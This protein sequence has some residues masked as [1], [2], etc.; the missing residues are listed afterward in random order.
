MAEV[1]TNEFIP[2]YASPPGETL[3]EILEVRGMSQAELAARMGMTPKTINEI[4]KGKAPITPETAIKLEQVLDVQAT[5]WN[6]R[7]Q[8][9]REILARVED[10][11][12]LGS[13]VSWLREIPVRELINRGAIPDLKDKTE[14]VQHALKFFGVASE[15]QWHEVWEIVPVSYRKSP[16]VESSF[17]SLAAWLRLGELKAQTIEC[18][19][20]DEKKF[21]ESLA[22][23]RSL[24]MQPP[25]V[26][27]PELKRLCAKSGV[28]L[29][30]VSE[31]QKTRVSGAIRWV[32]PY[33]AI[34][35]L[36]LRYK[37]DDQFWFTFFHEAGHVILHSSKEIFLE[38][39]DHKNTKE[40]EADDFAANFLVPPAEHKRLMIEGYSSK[41]AIGGFAKSIGVAPGIVVGRLQHDGLLPMSYC[42]DLKRRF[43]L[44]D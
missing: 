11:G 22:A 1:K 26:F 17:G 34:I 23:M 36:S 31:L 44:I 30:F 9:F 14:L 4:V 35:Q 16:K 2:N 13:Q 5:F 29:V 39:M 3:A 32:N 37:S 24:T 10:K 19:K 7:E 18:D 15:T 40:N 41:A 20:Y 21:K 43:I 8:H 6:T 33:K 28:A 27:E 38:G 25:K 12:R 42:N